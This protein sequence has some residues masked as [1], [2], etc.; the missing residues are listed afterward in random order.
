MNDKATASA[1]LWAASN[2][3]DVAAYVGPNAERFRA[4]WEKSRDQG[5]A[6]KAGLVRSWNWAAFFLSFGWWAYRKQWLVAAVLLIV[7]IAVSLLLPR[8]GSALSG[9]S[10]IIT[11]ISKPTYIQLA[12]A[13]IAKIKATGGNRDDIIS[14]GGVSLPAGII[15]GVLLAIAIVAVLAPLF[16]HK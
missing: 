9:A 14:A 5:V 7:P 11:M 8:S 12:V 13:R 2:W 6:G 15:A 16:A 3:D 1:A 4:A 10:I